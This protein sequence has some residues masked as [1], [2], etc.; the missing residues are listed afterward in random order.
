MI[1]K[2]IVRASVQGSRVRPYEV[3]IEIREI[4]AKDNLQIIQ[5]GRF[6]H[7]V[8]END[9]GSAVSFSTDISRRAHENIITIGLGDSLNDLPMLRAVDHPVLVKKPDA[10]H[11]TDIQL[12]NLIRSP[13]K[14]PVGWNF[15]VLEILEKLL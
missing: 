15:S 1:E 10:T 3:T 11:E 7:L 6:Y 12:D 9:K 4:A 8:G 13:G 2:G 14:G 5:G